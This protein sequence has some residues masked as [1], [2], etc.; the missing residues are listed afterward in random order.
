MGALLSH[1]VKRVTH[2]VT[3][4]GPSQEAS[5][6]VKVV[7]PKW[8]LYC[9]M[10]MYNDVCNQNILNEKVWL[11]SDVATSGLLISLSSLAALRVAHV[12]QL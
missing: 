12:C 5:R 3:V 2:Y 8:I 7:K 10:F 4:D 6:D 1:N 11:L 9:Y